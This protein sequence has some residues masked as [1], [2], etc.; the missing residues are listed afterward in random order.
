M[1]QGKR[2]GHFCCFDNKK[3]KNVLPFGHHRFSSCHTREANLLQMFECS[4]KKKKSI[5]DES[6]INLFCAS[7]EGEKGKCKTLM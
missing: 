6:W 1:T 2:K 4:K 5:N 7:P 3:K